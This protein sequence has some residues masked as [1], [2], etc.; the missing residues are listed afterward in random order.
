MRYK[1]L[2]LLIIIIFPSCFFNKEGSFYVSK[3]REKNQVK[4]L[5]ITLPRGSIEIKGWANDFIEI[6]SNKK[7]KNKLSFDSRLIKLDF[8]SNKGKLEVTVSIPER[9]RGSL[10]LKIN[11]PYNLMKII[12]NT[13]DSNIKINDFFGDAE[14]NSNKGLIDMD[15]QGSIL[16]VVS[17]ESTINLNINTINSSDIFIKNKTGDVNVNVSAVRE[18]SFLDIKS[19]SGNIYLSIN[20][21][22]SHRFSLTYKN[23]ID[24]QY[25]Y[26]KIADMKGE[27]NYLSG[28]V[29]NYS[30]K[31]DLSN[32][33][34]KITMLQK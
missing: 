28:F 31:I 7:I 8:I 25:K 29:N 32:I 10:D 16:R 20:K 24:I 2:F 33:N 18:D 19:L 15:F 12:I 4:L 22:I 26:G 3:Y 30:Y 27:Y 17:E 21:E 1:L 11:V 34:G 9:V 14:I 23:E 6:E 13:Q 5:S